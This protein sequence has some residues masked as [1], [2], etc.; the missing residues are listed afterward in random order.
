MI[1]KPL[2][3]GFDVNIIYIYIYSIYNVLW[4]DASSTYYIYIY[5]RIPYTCIYMYIVYCI[6]FGYLYAVTRINVVECF[7]LT[8]VEIGPSNASPG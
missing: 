8:P 7:V 6:L 2:I 3:V 1:K 5:K 4:C